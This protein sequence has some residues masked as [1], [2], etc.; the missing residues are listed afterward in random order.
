MS[1]AAQ[2]Q[3]TT[4][5]TRPE[6]QLTSQPAPSGWRARLRPHRAQL[7]IL[8][9]LALIP[10]LL[11]LATHPAIILAPDS[12]EYIATAAQIAHTGKL[13]DAR[14]T[15]GYPLLLAL[16]FAV[17]GGRNLGAV[18]AV[19][20]ALALLTPFGVYLLA[21]RLTYRRWVA[22]A[23]AGL[24]AINLYM[25]DW[26]YSIRDETF[27]SL[28]TVALFL[29]TERLVRQPRPGWIVGFGVL[30]AF[31]I[32]TRPIYVFLPGIILVALAARALGMRRGRALLPGIALACVLVYGVIAGYAGVNKL[33]NGYLGIS[34]ISDVN[35]FG[36]VIEYRLYEQPVAPQFQ[37]MQRQVT[38]FAAAGGTLPWDFAREYGYQG[39]NYAA[40]GAFARPLILQHPVQYAIL[41]LHDLK[42]VWLV[43]PGID[44]RG[45]RILAFDLML[46]LARLDLL[47][48]LA[49][50]VVV[51]WLA[52]L[53]WRGWRN[54]ALFTTALLL[55]AVLG[56]MLMTAVGSYAEYYRLRAPIDWA[57]LVVFALMA[58]DAAGAA[59]QWRRRR[60]LQQGQGQVAPLQPSRHA[61]PS[62]QGAEQGAGVAQVRD[63]DRPVRWPLT[64]LRPPFAVAPPRHPGYTA[65]GVPDSISGSS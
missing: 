42:Q 21:Y 17:T 46:A 49:L 3:V 61:P 31:L 64:R 41:T 30:G 63:P 37:T 35:L 2:G 27:S 54:P 52:W 38:V 24:V 23:A 55:L 47:T 58:F 16:I 15:P 39:N 40:L 20:L 5:L 48:Y 6:I 19:Q 32:L 51:F 1:E 43:K 18:V 57:Y 11:L 10:E 65:R 45:A 59:L 50:P 7:L 22:C 33:E 4:T 26:T 36:K 53:L 28:L 60:V 25:I 56:S 9:I 62:P 34:Y 14:R 13:V 12:R 8:L 29:V 44:S